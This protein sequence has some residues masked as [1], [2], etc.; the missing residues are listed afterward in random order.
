MLKYA[1]KLL[2][3][4]AAYLDSLQDDDD[5]TCYHIHNTPHARYSLAVGLKASIAIAVKNRGKVVG[6]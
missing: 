5:A 2:M 4:Y 6:R 3:L 1:N